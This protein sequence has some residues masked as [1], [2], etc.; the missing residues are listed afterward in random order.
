MTPNACLAVRQM[1]ESR[2]TATWETPIV[3]SNAMRYCTRHEGKEAAYVPSRKG[4]KQECCTAAGVT[5]GD[6]ALGRPRRQAAA[7]ATCHVLGLHP[8]CCPGY[9]QDSRMGVDSCKCAICQ[10]R[11]H[12]SRQSPPTPGCHPMF[13]PLPGRMYCYWQAGAPWQQHSFTRL[14][15]NAKFRHRAVVTDLARTAGAARGPTVGVSNLLGGALSHQHSRMRVES[16][17]L[18]CARHLCMQVA[19]CML[20]T[21]IKEPCKPWHHY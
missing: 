5:R 18:L 4:L 21:S 7:R 2:A 16:Q 8:L 20:G 1:S 17:M 12:V 19:R 6:P 13:D 9:D 11:A 15:L 3:L 10:Q 14:I